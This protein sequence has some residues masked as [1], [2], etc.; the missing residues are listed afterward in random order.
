MTKEEE[1]EEGVVVVEDTRQATRGRWP[2]WKQ[3]GSDVALWVA[4]TAVTLALMQRGGLFSGS[5]NLGEAFLCLWNWSPALSVLLVS[6]LSFLLVVLTFWSWGLIFLFKHRWEDQREKRRGEEEGEEGMDGAALSMFHLQTT[7]KPNVISALF[8]FH[9]SVLEE[10]ELQ[11]LFE[12]RLLSK[13]NFRRFMQ[14]AKLPP[15][16]TSDRSSSWLYHVLFPWADVEEGVWQSANSRWDLSH[17]FR[18][19]HLPS[20]SCSSSSSSSSSSCSSS[21]SS[22]AKICSVCKANLCVNKGGNGTDQEVRENEE[23]TRQ[24]PAILSQKACEPMDSNHP[25]WRVW[26]IQRHPDDA[27]ADEEDGHDHACSGL[28]VQV[29]HAIGD[30]FSLLRCLLSIADESYAEKRGDLPHHSSLQ[31]ASSQYSNDMKTESNNNGRNS[32]VMQNRDF[33]QRQL[34]RLCFGIRVLRMFPGWA[35]RSSLKQRGGSSRFFLNATS[36]PQQ[37]GVALP[38]VQA[39]GMAWLEPPLSLQQVKRAARKHSAT[40][41]DVLSAALASAIRAYHHVELQQSKCKKEQI[42]EEEEELKDVEA[43]VPVGSFFV[44]RRRAGPPVL[45]NHFGLVFLRLPISRNEDGPAE[46]LAAIK[47]EMDA[48]KA[49]LDYE[50]SYRFTRWMGR[51]ASPF[52]LRLLSSHVA[53]N[54]SVIFTNVKG[55]EEGLLLGGKSISRL[56]FFVPTLLE[57]TPIGLSILSYN[58]HISVG[59]SYNQQQ[60]QHP[61][62]FLQLFREQVSLLSS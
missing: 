26:I 15:S 61:H 1:R 62:R 3:T 29:H 19:V 10:K 58:G 5:A 45:D 43:V 21:S 39:H 48:A 54:A 53:R 52:W 60:I 42:E 23:G 41:N 20:S 44:A 50:F 49:T 30:G 24:I 56:C 4:A 28:L 14:K 36:S 38:Q 37:Q 51:F 12:E 55:P 40:I 7:E 57:S 59:L 18:T 34:D 25:L 9:G 17:H 16:A 47:K 33:Y 11:R 6:A 22:S 35:L 32:K 13:P 8:W 27:R 31:T 2:R 46:R